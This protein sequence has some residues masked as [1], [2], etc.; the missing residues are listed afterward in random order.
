MPTRTFQR[1]FGCKR[2]AV[3][4]CGNRSVKARLSRGAV[5]TFIALSSSI[6]RKKERSVEYTG[7][8]VRSERR[9][10]EVKCKLIRQKAA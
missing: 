3:F 6:T 10:S 1:T 7:R 2:L 4:K 8:S 9:A 5:N